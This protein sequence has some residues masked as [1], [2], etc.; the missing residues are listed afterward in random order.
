MLG[1]FGE[2]FQRTE[3][4]YVAQFE[5]HLT[6]M[7]LLKDF[8]VFLDSIE[9]INSGEKLKSKEKSVEV[10]FLTILIIQKIS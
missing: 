4:L 9:G 10:D 6:R 1:G 3:S 8:K 7:E 5:I 2:N